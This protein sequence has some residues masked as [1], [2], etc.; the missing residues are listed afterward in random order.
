MC[1]FVEGMSSN[2]LFLAWLA[3]TLASVALAYVAIKAADSGW[4]GRRAAKAAR[5]RA[6][7]VRPRRIVAPRHV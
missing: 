5:G 7:L 3:A 6:L 2:P 1:A 4:L